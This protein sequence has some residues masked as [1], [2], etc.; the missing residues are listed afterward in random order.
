MATGITPAEPRLMVLESL[1]GLMS[2]RT[3]RDDGRDSTRVWNGKS[4]GPPANSQSHTQRPAGFGRLSKKEL[5]PGYGSPTGP[6]NMPQAPAELRTTAKR[7]PVE[8]ETGVESVRA[9]KLGGDGKKAG[10]VAPGIVCEVSTTPLGRSAS[11]P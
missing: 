10:S 4:K 5:P 11:T 8:S 9:L 2:I 3:D 1:P 6:R 7:S